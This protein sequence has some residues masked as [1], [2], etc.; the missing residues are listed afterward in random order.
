MA[1][2]LVE[3]G[4][5]EPSLPDQSKHR[6]LRRMTG[7]K[8][9]PPGLPTIQPQQSS[10]V[11]PGRKAFTCAHEL[12]YEDGT[13]EEVSVGTGTMWYNPPGVW[14]TVKNTG[15][16]PLFLVFVTPPNEERKASFILSP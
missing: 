4:Q 10:Q 9:S 11:R 16:T 6:P 13:D 7:R 12:G 5:Q 3:S 14:H 15:S 2:S 8:N 1:V